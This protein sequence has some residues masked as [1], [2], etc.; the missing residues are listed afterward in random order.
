MTTHS[1]FIVASNIP[2]S[3]STDYPYQTAKE[4]SKDH[5]VIL[6]I[7]PPIFL[8]DY[9]FRLEMPKILTKISDNLF[10][11]RTLHILPFRRF[12]VIRTIN[13]CL[14]VN[15]L[16]MIISFLT[17]IQQFKK[18]VLWVFDPRF[19]HV[20]RYIHTSILVYDCVDYIPGADEQYLLT[21][22][23]IAVVNSYTLRNIH[24]RIRPNIRVVPQGFRLDEFQKHIPATIRLPH[25]KPIIGYIGAISDRLDYHL[26]VR[27][28]KRL[29]QYRF[30]FVGPIQQEDT[31]QGKQWIEYAKDNLF[32][33]SNVT[34]IEG[35]EKKGVKNIISQFAIGMIPY[36]IRQDFNRYCFPMKVFEYF[37]MGKPVV[38]TPI[39]ELKRFPRF[40][41]IGKTAGEWEKIVA[42]ILAKPWPSTLQKEQ[43]KEAQKNSW[44]RKIQRIKSFI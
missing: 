15:V 33:L 30:L 40:V 23:D 17:V 39:E 13:D 12:A 2:L 8:K 18:T 28:A 31:L 37:F 29:P 19:T 24:K 35:V 27:L 4:L 32:C 5:M 44:E 9:A 25:D 38:S 1:L 20:Y 11:F 22:A 36:D 6:W 21:R 14:S 10:V 34:V 16:R 42:T 41:K 43:K 26:L 7:I 3:W